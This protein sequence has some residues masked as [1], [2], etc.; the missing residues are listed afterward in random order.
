VI[1]RVDERDGHIFLYF[2][3]PPK[4]ISPI[5]FVTVVAHKHGQILYAKCSE[6]GYWTL[7]SGRVEPGETAEVAAHRELLEET[8]AT[9][10]NLEVLCYVHSFMFG[11]DYWGIT[12]IGEVSSL[13]TF[14]DTDE[15][16]EVAFWSQPPE[17]ISDRFRGQSEALYQAAQRYLQTNGSDV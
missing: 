9:V 5:T 1:Q 10:S 6:E 16:A 11:L 4:N 15:I 12:Y 7:P 13:G 8:G 17:P 2:G 3:Q 14:T